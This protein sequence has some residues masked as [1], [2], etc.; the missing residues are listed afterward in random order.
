MAVLFLLRIV[1]RK[2]LSGGYPIN[3]SIRLLRY[4]SIAMPQWPPEEPGACEKVLRVSIRS[5]LLLLIAIAIT[6]ATIVV[7]GASI[8][9]EATRFAHSKQAEI[10][11]TAQVFASAAAE[12]VV[13]LNRGEAL[14][15]LRAMA[16]I[17]GITYSG[18]ETR[19]GRILAELGLNIQLVREPAK[20]S[21]L[22]AAFQLL[23]R[24]S[25]SVNVPIISSG[26]EVGRLILMADT[27]DLWTS[28]LGA[29]RD[30]VI[31]GLVAIAIGFAL[32]FFLQRSIV[33]R[34]NAIVEAMGLIQNRHD[35]GQRIEQSGRDELSRIATGFNAMLDEIQSRDEKL[36][37]HRAALEFEVEERTRDYR[38]AKEAADGANAAK[39]EFLATMSHEIRTPM[40]GILVMAE[41]LA[42]SDL[43]PKQKRF[44]DVIARSGS[45]LLAII[46][47]ILDFS[48]IEAGKIELETIAVSVDDVIETVAQL[49]EEKARSKGLDL[50]SH[51]A[52]NVPPRI[53]AD[54]TRLNQVLA[55]LV[56]NALKFTE[57]GSVNLTLDRAPD[58][59]S[60]LRFSVRDTG[61]GI[62]KDK[63]ASVF[64]AFSQADQTTT[65]RFGG[66]GLGLAICRRLVDAMGGEIAIESE[67]GVGS[68][69]H[70]LIPI[71]HVDRLE[72]ENR[73]RRI[74]SGKVLLA[75][76]GSATQANLTKY[77]E[78]FGFE[79]SDA[80]AGAVSRDDGERSLVIADSRL[81]ADPVASRLMRRAPT[82]ALASF[83]DAEADRL[84]A[85]GRAQAQ[86][87]KPIARR[88]LF[89]AIQDLL[90]GES[91][92]SRARAAQKRDSEFPK[93]PD[94]LILVA[95]D[96]PVNREV[97]IETLRRFDLP[98]DTV[99]DGRA[100]L[101]AVQAKHYDLVFMDGSMPDMDGFESTRAIRRWE[102][103]TA[104]ERLPII[105]LTAHVVG[106][107]AEAW[108][109]AGM[110]GVL[111]KPF[112]LQAM[113]EMLGKHL[114]PR[115]PQQDRR[116]TVDEPAI[117]MP[118]LPAPRAVTPLPPA[119]LSP[120]P[121]V[122]ADASAILD[123]ATTSQM[124]DMAKIAS[125]DAV[126]RI[127]RLYLENGP[128]AL[129]EIEAAIASGEGGAVAKA[130][131]A[132]K[133]MS[134]S[135]GA[136]RVAESAGELEKSGRQGVAS[137]YSGLRDEIR[138][139]LD[140]AYGA[141]H[142]L[143]AEHGFEKHS[144]TIEAA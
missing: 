44:A 51:I 69:F 100:A 121:M 60:H 22:V 73:V 18:I 68:A 119:P 48:K 21:G 66:T 102:T 82:I 135:L 42:A 113:A 62:A 20:S 7:T 61:I 105:A 133:S 50:S 24:D 143:Q 93:F 104:R 134:L 75:V 40:N 15:V 35:Y 138:A 120:T 55:N 117:S 78:E 32:V 109:N 144:E 30:A 129:A 84:I 11:A 9:R 112:T 131:H 4:L 116:V 63:I 31:A 77:L 54:P 89:Q 90:S 49:F 123:P 85:E 140:E 110:D 17:S 5:R 87:T 76:S 139:R 58:K 72:G 36:A 74:G 53:G 130:A 39:S 8:H 107:H 23:T 124:L 91:P 128:P 46:N 37:R 27:S 70:V 59:P 132:L 141:I 115:A 142:R 97:V 14:R 52:P 29:V 13:G 26:D 6:S 16:R 106:S 71:V 83:G 125:A 137:A 114:A 103:E 122:D 12:A 79:I 34:I 92:A 2:A 19:D 41:L 81:L 64:E 56:N 25:M 98:C 1:R 86:I 111:H 10:E 127:Y 3:L 43:Q 28:A 57:A 67:I 33:A 94:H 88:E 96:N 108:K 80:I 118:P 95:D 99:A 136:A 65:R 101:N 47:D 45:S 126:A 38:L